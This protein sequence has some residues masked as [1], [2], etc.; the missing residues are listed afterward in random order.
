M[1][2][3]SASI[4]IVAL[5]LAETPEDLGSGEKGKLAELRVFGELLKRGFRVY[6]PMVDSEGI[7]CLV[8]VGEGNYKEIQVKWREKNPLFQV[9]RY[10][11]RPSFYIVC[12]LGTGSE[13]EMWVIPS[14]AFYDMGK[15]A[16]ADSREYIRL[17]IGKEGH[18]S[19]EKLRQYSFN[20]AQLLKGATKE[21]KEVVEHASKRIEEPH[22]KQQDFERAILE[23]L[24]N[25]R[26]PMARKRIIEWVGSSL[27]D[28]FSKADMDGISSG[29]ARWY[30]NADWAITNLKRKGI[31]QAIQKNQYTITDKGREIAHKAMLRSNIPI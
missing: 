16:K 22:F 15:R 17:V 31:I 11:P 1:I 18:E 19:Y 6:T 5:E 9:R 21:V 8:D 2:R 20:F 14:K 29:K 25:E 24:T 27:K 10:N 12:C 13:G 26:A 4:E 3:L 23:I 30:K 7:D 28:R